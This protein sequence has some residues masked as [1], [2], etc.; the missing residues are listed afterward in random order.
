[1][2]TNGHEK[3]KGQEEIGGSGDQDADIW[4]AGDQG[5]GGGT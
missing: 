3:E 1:M 4:M 5:A 2:N